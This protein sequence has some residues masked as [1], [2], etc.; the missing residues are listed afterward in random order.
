MDLNSYFLLLITIVAGVVGQL[1]LKHGMSQR[2]DFRLR[3]LVA[4]SRDFSI[5]GGFCCYG[6]G[7]LLYLKVL[8]RL[9]LSLAYPSISLGYAL[10]IVMSRVLFK[11]SVSRSR[12]V[13]VTIICVGVALVALAPAHPG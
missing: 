11:E 5:F 2:P 6:I 4:L 1:L 13:A 10:V 8:A 7:T 12:W 9:D 3:D